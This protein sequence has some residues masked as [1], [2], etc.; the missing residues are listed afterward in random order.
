MQ[1]EKIEEPFYLKC[2]ICL[3]KLNYDNNEVFH[4]SCRDMTGKI[5]GHIHLCVICYVARFG[6]PKVITLNKNRK[7]K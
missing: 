2:D 1:K 3:S 5:N 4:A 7:T 6:K